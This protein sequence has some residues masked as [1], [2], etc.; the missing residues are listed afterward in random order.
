VLLSGIT[1]FSILSYFIL[2]IAFEPYVFALA[3]TI[4]SFQVLQFLSRQKPQSKKYILV[5]CTHGHNRTGYMIVNYIMRSHPTSVTQV[6][7]LLIL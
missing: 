7:C 3:L 2:Q 5:H 1:N 6:C 4:Y